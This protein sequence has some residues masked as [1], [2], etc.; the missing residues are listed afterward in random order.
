[1]ESFDK[2]LLENF[3]WPVKLVT[4]GEEDLK[5]KF[6]KLASF[7]KF[8]P[9]IKFMIKMIN[10]LIKMVYFSHARKILPNFWLGPGPKMSSP[11]SG[12]H[13][14]EILDFPPKSG[15]RTFLESGPM[16]DQRSVKTDSKIDRFLIGFLQKWPVFVKIDQNLTQFLAIFQKSAYFRRFLNLSWLSASSG[17][18]FGQNPWNWPN[19]GQFQGFTLENRP[20][21]AIFE[22]VKKWWGSRIIFPPKNERAGP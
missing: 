15:S 18:Q 8:A 6:D 10:I 1:M 12:N 9:F 14:G 21:W 5:D 2:I 13:F 7:I 20:F 17:N 3:A 4:W 22:E 11:P 16:T 19:Q